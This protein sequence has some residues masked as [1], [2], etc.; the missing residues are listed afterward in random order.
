[1]GFI[2]LGEEFFK[3]VIFKPCLFLKMQHSHLYVFLK[4]VQL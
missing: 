1:M 3:N 2:I 4:T